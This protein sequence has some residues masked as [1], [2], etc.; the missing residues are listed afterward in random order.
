[1]KAKPDRRSEMENERRISL[2]C[3]QRVEGS[4][5]KCSEVYGVGVRVWNSHKIRNMVVNTVIEYCE[6]D[7]SQ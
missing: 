2:S 5:V 4:E 3:G 7:Y 1:M 6:N